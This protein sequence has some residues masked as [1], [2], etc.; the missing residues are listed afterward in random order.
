MCSTQLNVTVGALD[1]PVVAFEDVKTLPTIQNTIQRCESCSW[2]TTAEKVEAI[3]SEIEAV[4]QLD[5]QNDV[6]AQ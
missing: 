6:I 3:E 5:L 2:E 1:V 4:F